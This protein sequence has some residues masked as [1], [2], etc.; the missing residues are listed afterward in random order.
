MELVLGGCFTTSGFGPMHLTKMWT[1]D[2]VNILNSIMLPYL[3]EV[4]PSK[5]E[6][7]TNND[8]MHSPNCKRVGSWKTK[9]CLKMSENRVST[10]MCIKLWKI[11]EKTWKNS[12]KHMKIDLKYEKKFLKII[13]N[14]SN[15]T[16]KC[17]K[18]GENC[19][20]YVINTEN[21][22]KTWKKRWKIIVKNQRN[23][24]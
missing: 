12:V 19:Q 15:I 14:R 4:M 5:W 16:G 20:V 7:M 21:W 6:F 10:N 3:D 23:S 18:T 22:S 11:D 1:I 13:E 24:S 17:W 2:Y 8:P 9:N